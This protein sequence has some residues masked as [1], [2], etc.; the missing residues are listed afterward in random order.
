MFI[1]SWCFAATI[2]ADFI[3]LLEGAGAPRAAWR[4]QNLCTSILKLEKEYLY[5]DT[6]SNMNTAAAIKLI[7]IICSPLT[8]IPSPSL[9]K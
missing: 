7:P 4:S 2:K 3:T 5:K 8:V 9:A 1:N 6:V